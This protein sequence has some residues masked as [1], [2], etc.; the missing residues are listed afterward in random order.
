MARKIVFGVFIAI[1]ALSLIS[2]NGDGVFLKPGLAQAADSRGLSEDN[3]G[4]SRA[5]EVQ[6]R[7]SEILM[8]LPDVVGH[9]IGVS[10]DGKDKTPLTS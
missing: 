9:G 1:F 8:G 6:G 5:I 4:I 10:S 2:I 7:H 3:P